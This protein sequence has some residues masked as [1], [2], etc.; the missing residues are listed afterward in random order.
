MWRFKTVEMLNK[1][2][3]IFWTDGG[4]VFTGTNSLYLQISD[5]QEVG[6]ST[7]QWQWWRHQ[8]NTNCVQKDV[9]LQ[10]NEYDAHK[11]REQWKTTDVY[12]QKH[13]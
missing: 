11:P 4:A 7:V 5:E 6:G 8:Q 3:Y 2:W 10:K 9:Y 1:S 13:Y 12:T